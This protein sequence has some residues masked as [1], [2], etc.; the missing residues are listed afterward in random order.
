[1]KIFWIKINKLKYNDFINQISNFEK[2]N[3]IFTPNP[4]ILLKTKN[5]DEFKKILKKATYLTPDG[6]GIYIAFQILNNNYGKIL[7]IIF[8]PYYFFNLFFKKKI[9]I[10]KI[11]R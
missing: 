5:D 3:I 1:M 9:F 8:L 6:I 2:Q 4:E 10:W 7:N 11:L